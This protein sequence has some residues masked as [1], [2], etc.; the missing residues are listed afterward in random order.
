MD[1]S[2]RLCAPI[3]VA[4]ALA[5]LL[6]LSACASTEIASSWRDP[7]DKGGP[8]RKLIVFAA[9]SDD[10]VR[11][12]AETQAVQNLPPGTK[13]VPSFT[14]F[15]KPEKD[16]EKI[17]ARLTLDGFDGALISRLA[18]YDSSETYVPPQTHIA[19]PYPFFRYSPHYGSFF[20]YYPYAY[21]Y[22]S[23]GY[24]AQTRRYA[25]ETLLYRLPEGKPVWSAV[26]ETINPESKLVLVSE[27]VRA[28]TQEL[29][30]AKLLAGN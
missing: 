9:T 26:S 28:V 18:S 20:R 19:Q 13:G 21:T 8:I 27:V 2:D 24:V 29:E 12:L 15:D 1:R 3:R 10:A 17:R 30:K 23:P 7:E 25:V 6:L 11:R 16:I 4:L 14:L 22:V 5:A